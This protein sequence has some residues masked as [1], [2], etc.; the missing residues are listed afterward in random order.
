[1]SKEEITD[2]E[3]AWHIIEK[4]WVLSRLSPVGFYMAKGLAMSCVQQI[5]YAMMKDSIIEYCQDEINK[6]ERVKK[7]I[8]EYKFEDVN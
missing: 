3:Q 4:M 6:W 8:Y 1:M 5:I 2:K 7:H